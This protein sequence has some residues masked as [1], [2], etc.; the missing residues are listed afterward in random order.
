MDKFG[1]DFAERLAAAMKAAGYEAKPSVLER[2]FN[3]R[4]WG[5]PITL[6][7][8]RRWLRGE[9]IPPH[10]KIMTLAEWLH[11][12]PQELGFGKEIEERVL[13]AR[14]RWDEGIGYEERDIFEAFLKL[15][16][17]HRR[18]VREVIIAFSRAYPLNEN[19]KPGLEKNR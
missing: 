19:P 1:A 8:V 3:Q 13:K 5:K 18:L 4:Y 7:G 15:S 6:Q 11:V 10:S 16:M 14:K 12:T 17:P 2:E 9:V